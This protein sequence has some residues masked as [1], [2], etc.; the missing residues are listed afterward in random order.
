MSDRARTLEQDGGVAERHR[1][2][3]WAWGLGASGFVPVSRSLDHA[4]WLAAAG[5]AR[6]WMLWG[7]AQPTTPCPAHPLILHMLD[8]AAV[9]AR[10]ITEVLPA[11]LSARLLSLHPDPTEAL[12]AVLFVVAMHDLGKAT[13][14]FQRKVD[15][16]RDRLPMLGFD[17]KTLDDARHHGDVGMPLVDDALRELG[18]GQP[19]ARQLARAVA[20]HHGEFPTDERQRRYRSDRREMGAGE[21]WER[22]RTGLVARFASLLR[23]PDFAGARSVDH[24]YPVILA[25]LTSVADWIGSNTDA[26]PYEPPGVDLARYWRAALQRADKGLALAGLRAASPSPRRS[27]AELFPFPTPWPLHQLADRLATE[28][29]GPSLAIVEAPMGEGK[30]EAAL[31]LADAEAAMGRQGLY[32][33]LPTQATANQMF[34]RLRRHLERTGEERSTLLLAHSEAELVSAFQQ[35]RLAA[36][37]D[38][39][40]AVRAEG[41]FLSKKRK[42]LAPYAVG[43]VDQALLAVMRIPHLF[44]RLFGLAGKTVVLDEVHAYDTY[45]STLLDR[46]VEWL[47][48]IGASVV[49]LSATLPSARRRALEDAYRRGAGWSERRA[50]TASYPRVTV[51]SRAGTAAHT[52]DARRAAN[53]LKVA[54][55]R[56]DEDVEQLAERVSSEA[57]RG[58]CVGWIL[59]TVAR[60]QQAHVRVRELAPDL[61]TILVHARL[62]PDE[63]ARRQE[64]LEEWLGRGSDHRP[65]RCL[66]IGTQVLEQSLDVDFDLMVS[67]VAPIDLLLQRAGRLWR[68]ERSGRARS[69]P[70]LWVSRPDRDAL[71]APLDG[72]AVVYRDDELL[73]RRTLQLLDR[74]PTMQL[75]TDIEPWVEE[76]YAE[77]AVPAEDPLH[78]AW[79]SRRGGEAQ[80]ANAAKDKLLKRPNKD[81]LGDLKVFL[82]DDDDPLLH[83]A[84]RPDTRLGPR[85]VSVVC[86]DRT[87][88]VLRAGEEGPVVD[89]A[90]EPDGAL[91]ALLVR[92]SISVTRTS[93]VNALLAPGSA[94]EVPAWARSAVLRHRRVVVLESGRAVVGGVALTADPELGLVL[95]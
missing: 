71:A 73:M 30:T 1:L 18:A 29:D 20:A 21:A 43:T 93:V 83:A 6:E 9:A 85:S 42:L 66:V 8:V 76:V 13:P 25:G 35:V 52:F 45:T 11:A 95:G 40:G 63:R 69:A 58:G 27:F 5:E 89:L 79:L 7:K 64:A 67:D 56:E 23:P 62:F 39:K 15:W 65:E 32:V 88:D 55:R 3:E 84:A 87:G 33:G 75:P 34:G 82:Q 81:R 28:V 47:G 92:R 77:D 70:E 36:I 46:L 17:M 50:S 22:A 80:K 53:P 41:W 74:E 16:A 68:H 54:L 14:A 57:A 24:A 61:P 4:D 90:R 12:R 44:V 78:S 72:A 19:L 49:L 31:L 60:A 26:F 2:Q 59:N 48:A 86:L 94:H 91:T 51:A 37:Y 10:L 38:D